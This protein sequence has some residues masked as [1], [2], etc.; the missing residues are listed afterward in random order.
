MY[1][2]GPRIAAGLAIAATGAP[3]SPTVG[4]SS[5]AVVTGPQIAET[6]NVACNCAAWA[7]A[8]DQPEDV[9]TDRLRVLVESG[10]PHWDACREI[11]GTG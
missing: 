1:G 2:I 9:D 3:N 8:T 7:I 4:P 6:V 10:V 5:T 11:W